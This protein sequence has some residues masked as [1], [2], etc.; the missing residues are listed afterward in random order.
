MYKPG[1]GGAA[2]DSVTFCGTI[3][4]SYAKCIICLSHLA[5]RVYQSASV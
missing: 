2:R 1:F 3:A 4:S 5:D